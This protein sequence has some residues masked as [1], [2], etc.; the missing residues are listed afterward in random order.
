MAIKGLFSLFALLGLVLIVFGFSH[1]DK[2]LVYHP[3]PV[4]R[5]LTIALMA[6]SMIVFAGA[7][8]PTNLKRFTRHPMLWG[9]V[10][11]ALAHLLANGDR[12]AL[13]LFGGM[14]VYALLGML[15]ANRRGAQLQLHK[16]PVHKDVTTVAAGLVA[17]GLIIVLHPFL[18]GVAIF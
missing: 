10:C 4:L 11:W 12:A 16:L 9:L 17:Y 3:L 5:P 7:N 18:F 14:G 8:M 15:S 6:I 1:T 13:L 2:L